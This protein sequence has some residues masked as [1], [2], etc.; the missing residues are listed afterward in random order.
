MPDKGFATNNIILYSVHVYVGTCRGV[1]RIFLEVR[2]I[3]QIALPP[4]P[5][6]KPGKPRQKKY[7]HYRFGNIVNLRVFFGIWS[8]ISNLWNTLSGVWVNWLMYVNH[9]SY[10]EATYFSGFSNFILLPGSF[11]RFYIKQMQHMNVHSNPNCKSQCFVMYTIC[12]TYLNT[13]LLRKMEQ[14]LSWI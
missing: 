9:L 7:L 11:R 1:A 13:L 6:T 4:P 10:N 2:T 5:P 3:L 14:L 12:P 8:N